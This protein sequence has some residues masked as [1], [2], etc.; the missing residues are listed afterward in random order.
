MIKM[1]V[2]DIDG[3]MMQHGGIID[4]QDITALRSL[5]EQNVI[6]CFAS[7]RLDNE[8][9]KLMKEVGTNFHRI[10]V[11]GVFVYTYEDKQLLSA[12]FDSNILPDLLSITKE[13]PYFRYV[14]D[15]HNYYIEEKTP[16][17][18]ELEKQV[19]MTSVE[20]PNL[21][22]KID[23]TIFPN[24]ISVGGIKEDLQVL[25]KKI[26]EK[27]HGK[28]S[29]FISAEQCLDVMPPN[30]SKGSAISVL[31]QEFQIR[32]EEIA[33]IGDSYNDIP[34]FSLTPH[35]FAMSQADHAVKEHAQ[36]VVSSVK[37]AVGYVLSYNAKQHKNTTHSL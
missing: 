15:E 1:F 17:I 7:G 31:L 28:V 5:A 11:N 12:T 27:F 30:I 14:S 32:P 29:T 19:M 26:D 13:A 9:A 10:S 33:C 8:I 25:Q 6:L 24:K 36:H 4:D 23:D 16:F 18:H 20:E 22:Q 3:T 37:D 2:S 34:M 21:L 35:S